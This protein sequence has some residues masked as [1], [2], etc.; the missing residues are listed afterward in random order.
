MRAS[1]QLENKL[2]EMRAGVI[3]RRSQG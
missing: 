1:R 2:S 3:Q